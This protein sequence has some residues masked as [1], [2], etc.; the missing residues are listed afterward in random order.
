MKC[1]STSTMIR[2]LPETIWGILVDGTQWTEWNTTIVKLEGK[3]ALGQTVMVYAKISPERAFPVKVSEFV[4][5]ERMVWTSGMPLGLFKGKRTYRL[6]QQPDGIVEFSMQ[7]IFNGLMA[8]LI[9]PSIPDLQP[10]FDEFAAALKR[11]A[12]ATA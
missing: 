5:Y 1:F 11:R 3:I 9:T 2:A 6:A 7:E 12:E 4:P 8:P 10:S